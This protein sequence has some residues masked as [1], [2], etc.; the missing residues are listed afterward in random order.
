MMSTAQDDLLSWLPAARAGRY[1]DSVDLLG[2]ADHG[3][4]PVVSPRNVVQWVSMLGEAR[5]VLVQLV[6]RLSLDQLP[7]DEEP[8]AVRIS[9]EARDR[10]EPI[11]VPMPAGVLALDPRIEVVPL[12]LLATAGHAVALQHTGAAAMSLDDLLWAAR[13]ADA[14]S[15]L[16][17]FCR[18]LAA[19][20]RPPMFGWE[21]I[22]FWEWWRSNGKTF[23]VG[24]AAPSL[25]SIEPHWGDAEWRRASDQADLERALLATRLP[26]VSAF[27]VVERTG[28]RPA[29]ALCVGRTL[30]PAREQPRAPAAGANWLAVA[31][32][33]RARSDPRCGAGLG[34]AGRGSF[35]MTSQGPWRTASTPFALFGN[36]RT[37]GPGSLVTGSGSKL[38]W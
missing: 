28:R 13:T 4:G 21:A 3:T 11:R 22:D 26:P 6:A 20:D 15:D 9:R 30:G 24:G 34:R 17:M 27:D 37:T 35:C 1:G 5:A 2:P 31:S 33:S 36:R 38:P 10:T 29:R 32:Q 23:F 25:M 14:D 18:E 19:T 12:L 16:F 8:V 7:F